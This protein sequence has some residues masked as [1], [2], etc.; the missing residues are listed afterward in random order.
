MLKHIPKSDINL[1]PFK[2]YK[3]FTFTENDVAG[4]FAYNHTSSTDYLSDT[5]LDE[6]G[7]YHQLHTMYYRDPH[8]PVTSYG[9]INPISESFNSITSQRYLDGAAYVLPIKQKY[10]GEGIKPGSVI[11]NSNVTADISVDDTY[12]NLISDTNVF[13]LISLNIESGIFTFVD[14]QGN[15]NSLTFTSINMD[16][17]ILVIQGQTNNFI[18]FTANIT[19]DLISFVGI[20][21][22]NASIARN[23]IGNVF[24]SHG[25]ITITK[26]IDTYNK[27]YFND[28][29]LE[30]KS[31][32]TIY[33]NEYLLVVG[34]DEFNVSTNPTSYTEMNIETG[35]IYVTNS[36]ILYE[37]VAGADAGG[38]V[39][40]YDQ[41][42]QEKTFAIEPNNIY[43]FYANSF[44][45][46]ELINCEFT[47]ST[48]A[49]VKWRNSDKYQK[50]MFAEYEYSS[51]ID[52]IGS[53]LAPYIT[54]IG[55]YDDN[56]NM[57][58]VAKLAK[59]VKS[60]PDLPVNFLVRFDT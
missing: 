45:Y 21:E 46:C 41:N 27:N 50:P 16:D 58:A 49:G 20:I 8:N 39:N 22:G 59:P 44:G 5:E 25:I 28:Y 26:G 7:L 30:Y 38:I 31:T 34:E 6:Q 14:I 40:Y 23:T 13:T 48:K 4:L 43:N 33:E 2:V 57:V 29:E 17:G 55:L 15:Q 54:T 32:N 10:Y 19:D 24:Y 9:D 56:M 1:R 12:G 11:I 52:P 35:S 51:S 53:Y 3:T 37:I 36:N 18:N 60:M 42:N 47:E